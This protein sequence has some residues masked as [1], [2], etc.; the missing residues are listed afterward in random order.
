M[1]KGFYLLGGCVHVEEYLP[2]SKYKSVV[3]IVELESDEEDCNC[4]CIEH[5]VRKTAT[6]VAVDFT[7]MQ[8]YL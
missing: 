3:V 2:N 8:I 7:V 5:R 4:S 6:I 1:F